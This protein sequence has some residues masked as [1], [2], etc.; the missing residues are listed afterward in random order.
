[1]HVFLRP[2]TNQSPA[3]PVRVC[4]LPQVLAEAGPAGMR[5]E[6]IARRIQ[7]LGLRDLRTSRRV[8][9]Y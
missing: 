7:K 9:A 5:V 1:M 6:E 2:L 4:L 8:M 3:R